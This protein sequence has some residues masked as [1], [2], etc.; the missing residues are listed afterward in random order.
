MA[1]TPP[2]EEGPSTITS[3]FQTLRETVENRIELL[4]VELKE[5]YLR[6]FEA[7]VFMAAAMICGLMTLILLTLI[8]VVA[9]WDTHRMLVLGLLTAAYAAG[10]MTALLKLRS[11][12]KS[13]RP[14]SASLEEIK[15]DA[16][17]FKTPN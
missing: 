14:F 9:F 7:A 13:W 1:E 17:C 8:L 11:L 6:Q 12:L 3:I 16:A 10:T 2:P 5:E 15:K 4:L